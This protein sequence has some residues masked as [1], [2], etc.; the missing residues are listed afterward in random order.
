MEAHRAPLTGGSRA[1][2]QCGPGAANGY[3]RP[4]PVTSMG[5]GNRG[6]EGLPGLPGRLRI[7]QAQRLR[8]RLHG[9]TLPPTPL[10]WGDAEPPGLPDAPC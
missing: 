4:V 8:G 1:L 10:T 5:W 7:D 9:G 3:T 2:G 6:G